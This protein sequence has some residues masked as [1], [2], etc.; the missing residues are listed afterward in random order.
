MYKNSRLCEGARSLSRALALF[1]IGFALFPMPAR[2]ADPA[3]QGVWSGT[4]GKQPIVACLDSRGRSAYFYARYKREIPLTE[5]DGALAEYN[6]GEPTGTWTLSAAQGDQLVGQWQ[7][8]KSQRTSPIRLK[9]L[10]SADNF[11]PCGSIAYQGALNTSAPVTNV[12]VD[13]ILRP[14]YAYVANQGSNTI[15][16]YRINAITGVLT[17]LA[18]S[19]FAAG[20]APTS[21]TVNPAGTFAYVANSGDNTISAYRINAAMGTFTQVYGSP[22]AAGKDPEFVTL[23]PAGTFVYV[24]NDGSGTISAYRIN[25]ATGALT[26][27]H[28]SPFASGRGPQLVT[29]NL[30][31]TFAYVANAKSVIDNPNSNGS[32]SAYRINTTTGALAEVTGSPFAAGANSSS[33]TINSTNTF[34]Y[35]LNNPGTGNGSISAYRINATTGALTPI[36]SPFAVGVA[37]QSVTIVQP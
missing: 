32:I 18:G 36:G 4:L 22:F 9:K 20:V 5:K 16:A 13:R 3:W 8:P 24:A 7:N 23:N 6:K 30:A 26:Q 15:S 27:V 31:G 25:A 37:P 17:P 12:G 34:A 33:V 2:A 21:V 11:H 10:A 19:P 35:I 28:D 1:V 14:E 29:I